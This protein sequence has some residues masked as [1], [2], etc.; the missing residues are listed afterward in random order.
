MT[1][2]LRKNKYIHKLSLTYFIYKILNKFINNNW[3]IVIFLPNLF[4]QKS[5]FSLN[6]W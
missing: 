4:L 5:D 3:L 1:L 2:E 6:D